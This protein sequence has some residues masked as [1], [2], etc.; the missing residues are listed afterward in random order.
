MQHIILEADAMAIANVQRK[1]GVHEMANRDDT[2][3][4]NK[5]SIVDNGVSVKVITEWSIFVKDHRMPKTASLQ[6]KQPNPFGKE[7]LFFRTRLPTPI[8]PYSLDL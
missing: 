1:K 5:R 4:K 7:G 2:L 8:P 3:P 6:I